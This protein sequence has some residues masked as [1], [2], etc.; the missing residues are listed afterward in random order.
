MQI[1]LYLQKKY[2]TVKKNTL[3]RIF[4]LLAFI[5]SLTSVQAQDEFMIY[6]TIKVSGGTLQNT[7]IKV[8][9]ND[10]YLNIINE[11]LPIDGVYKIYLKYGKDYTI[12][13]SKPGYTPMVFDANLK[14]P[15][16]AK[17]CCYR[18]MHL[19][20]HM[21]KPDGENDE[22][23]EKTFHTIEYEKKLKGFNYSLD[24]DYMIQQRIVNSKIFREQLDEAHGGAEQRKK[25]IKEEKHY[26]ALINQA[27]VYY[28]K[29]Q[30]YTARK[31]FEEAQKI[32]PDRRYA[33]YKL[34]DIKTEL[35]LFET[36]ANLLGVNVDSIIASE[37]AQANFEKKEEAYP[38]FVPLTQEQIDEIFRKDIEQ[39]VIASSETTAEANRTLALMNEFFDEAF[40]PVTI[41]KKEEPIIEQ[42][43]VAERKA[44]PTV[45]PKEDFVEEQPK[46]R[47]INISEPPKPKPVV[48]VVEQPKQTE[49]KQSETKEEVVVEQKPIV[50]EIPRVV[51][52]STYQDSL[53]IVYPETRTVEVTQNAYKK[54]TRVIMNNGTTVEVYARVEHSWGATYYYLEEY[55]SGYQNIGY[56]AFMNR[57]KLFEIEGN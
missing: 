54:T 20:F 11:A 41:V 39:Q 45:K 36:K 6:G 4:T 8:R 14:L 30:F 55:P 1:I 12:T 17:Q 29:K 28:E 43:V 18:P 3:L 15:A 47:E 46:E 49:V 24:I 23:F 40:N 10:D 38:A 37:L 35:E 31:L 53:R 5:F 33:K 51:D 48:A 57:T 44:A 52:Y 13:F 34:E 25:A 26:L 42:P 16:D 7:N 9:S 2:I 56:S 27:T 19:S 50:R 32:R 21:F 22:L